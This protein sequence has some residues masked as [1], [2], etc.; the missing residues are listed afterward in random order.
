MESQR[1]LLSA[2]EET[3]SSDIDEIIC[4]DVNNP[5]NKKIKPEVKIKSEA[6]TKPEKPF[7]RRSFRS[8]DDERCSSPLCINVADDFYNDDLT[9]SVYLRV[10][11]GL[12]AKEIY[13]IILLMKESA[14]NDQLGY[15]T[16]RPL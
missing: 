2:D 3:I 13:S 6:S 9:L 15:N 8:T 11:K 4:L 12:S 5:E 1:K 16:T 10:S 7:M 14:Q